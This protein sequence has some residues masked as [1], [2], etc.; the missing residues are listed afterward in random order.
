MKWPINDPWHILTESGYLAWLVIHNR[1]HCGSYNNIFFGQGYY[2]NLSK[3]CLQLS[4]RGCLRFRPQDSLQPFWGTANQI[5][6]LRVDLC[7]FLFPLKCKSNFVVIFWRCFFCLYSSFYTVLQYEH[8]STLYYSMNSSM[9]YMLFF[10][11][12]D[13]CHVLPLLPWWGR[14]SFLSPNC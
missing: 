11:S 5:L 4:G 1:W 13:S 2:N 12:S 3:L 10:S 6:G 8:H 9:P 14:M 7:I